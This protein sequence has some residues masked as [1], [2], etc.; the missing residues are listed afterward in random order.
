MV[1]LE[2]T[3]VRGSFFMIRTMN[4]SMT[5]WW[6][7]VGGE[8]V[9]SGNTQASAMVSVIEVGVEKS[10]LEGCLSVSKGLRLEG[11]VLEVV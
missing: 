6:G 2:E 11:V 3:G 9:I 5:G 7:G 4:V 10:E 8:G 1:W